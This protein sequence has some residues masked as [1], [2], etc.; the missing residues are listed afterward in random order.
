M[1]LKP[2]EKVDL[3]KLQGPSDYMAAANSAETLENI[4][5]C[6]GIWIK[7]IEQVIR[8]DLQL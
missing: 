7:Q 8:G 5:E 1:T 4:E 3:C 2:Y 6:I